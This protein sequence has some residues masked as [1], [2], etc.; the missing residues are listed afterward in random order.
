MVSI[1]DTAIGQL[2]VMYQQRVQGGIVHCAFGPQVKGAGVVKSGTQLDIVDNRLHRL[3]NKGATKGRGLFYYDLELPEFMVYSLETFSFDI[4]F[5]ALCLSGQNRLTVEV[6]GIDHENG[7]LGPCGEWINTIFVDHQSVFKTAPIITELNVKPTVKTTSIF[8]KEIAI[9]NAV[10]G[11]VFYTESIRKDTLTSGTINTI[12]GKYRGLTTPT[13]KVSFGPFPEVSQRYK[14]IKIAI[15]PKFS[16]SEYD[17]V[18]RGS[19]GLEFDFG[20]GIV[21]EVLTDDFVLS[22]PPYID[23]FHL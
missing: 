22:V 2:E 15:Y 11:E 14:A 17:I 8:K 16:G 12:F 21:G 6:F 5:H 19:T 23:H 7:D 3:F 10:P 20:E 18:F 13:G 9:K 1:P 4:N